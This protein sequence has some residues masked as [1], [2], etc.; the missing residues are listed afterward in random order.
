MKVTASAFEENDSVIKVLLK[1][2]KLEF[3]HLSDFLFFKHWSDQSSPTNMQHIYDFCVELMKKDGL[4]VIHCSAGVGRSTTLAICCLIL[5]Q[6]KDQPQIQSW[7]DLSPTIYEMTEHF[8]VNRNPICV[9]TVD[10]F[11]FLFQFC[12][13]VS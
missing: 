3:T 9:Q 5:K 12:E 4:K 10:Q 11:R 13:F 8:R 2:E 6:F 7:K 1:Y